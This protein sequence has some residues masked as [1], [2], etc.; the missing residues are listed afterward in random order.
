MRDGDGVLRLR[1]CHR[2]LPQLTYSSHSP[3]C[4]QLAARLAS[5]HIQLRLPPRLD[6]GFRSQVLI[7][8]AHQVANKNSFDLKGLYQ[9][10]EIFSFNAKYLGGGGAIAVGGGKRLQD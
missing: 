9:F 6:F 7:E 10:K 4:Q 1:L 2:S 3:L 5:Y 8:T